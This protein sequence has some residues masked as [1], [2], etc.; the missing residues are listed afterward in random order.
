MLQPFLLPP[1]LPQSHCNH[2]PLPPLRQKNVDETEKKY[3]I[4]VYDGKLVLEPFL[5]PPPLAPLLHHSHHCHSACP[6]VPHPTSHFQVLG[7]C[8]SII[9]KFGCDFVQ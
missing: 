3:F 5:L 1:P 2:P 7:T 4:Y 6:W 8:N 9:V